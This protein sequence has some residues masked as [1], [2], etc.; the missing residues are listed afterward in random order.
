MKRLIEGALLSTAISLS[1][2]ES[3]GEQTAHPMRG[4][5]EA[6]IDEQTVL[7]GIGQC[8][9]GEV[10][11]TGERYQNLGDSHPR[12][13]LKVPV[14]IDNTS[15]REKALERQRFNGNFATFSEIYATMDNRD[16]NGKYD[17]NSTPIGDTGGPIDRADTAFTMAI[18]PKENQ[19]T[20]RVAVFVDTKT[21]P[22]G[23]YHARGGKSAT[24][25]TYCGI[26]EGKTD[27]TTGKMSWQRIDT[28]KLPTTVTKHK[29]N[30]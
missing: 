28:P 22:I 8:T 19:P 18:T 29:Y 27:E 16:A 3:G 24:S 6:L 1:T 25:T 4:V 14:T 9:L 21:Q 7:R 11:D 26:I 30:K 12:A 15:A 5:A 17:K 13:L 20:K 23:K 10:I 2:I